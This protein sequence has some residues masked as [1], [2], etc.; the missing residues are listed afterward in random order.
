[1]TTAPRPDRDER[2]DAADHRTEAAYFG[3]FLWQVPT[4]IAEESD[5]FGRLG[6]RVRFARAR[7]KPGEALPGQAGQFVGV[8]AGGERIRGD[9]ERRAQALEDDTPPGMLMAPSRAGG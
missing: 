4:P 7:G 9:G 5:E 6:P 1:M 3:I 2:P 8:L